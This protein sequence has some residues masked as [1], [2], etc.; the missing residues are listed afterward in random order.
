[1]SF[2]NYLYK[3]EHYEI[4]D[5]SYNEPAFS[6]H[7]GL[8][9]TAVI[10][11]SLQRQR[12]PYEFALLGERYNHDKTTVSIKDL[13]SCFSISHSHRGLIICSGRITVQQHSTNLGAK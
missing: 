5:Y 7:V 2:D 11:F 1:M 8:I 3:K 12:F 9:W 10:K 4:S 6:T 13:C